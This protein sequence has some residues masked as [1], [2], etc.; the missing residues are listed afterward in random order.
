MAR[1]IKR[2]SIQA[3]GFALLLLGVAGLILPIL[4]GTV[5]L[6]AGLVLLSVYSERAKRI[7]HKIGK[8][9]PQA[10]KTVQKVERWVLKVVGEA[11]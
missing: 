1:H 7:L 8:Q 9:H 10:E 4:N 3:V 2:I 11:A 5:F 6:L